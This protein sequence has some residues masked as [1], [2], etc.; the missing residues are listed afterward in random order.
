MAGVGDFVSFL[1][2]NP[3]LIFVT[4]VIGLTGIIIWWLITR[5]DNDTKVNDLSESKSSCIYN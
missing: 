4:I 3:T 1:F 2:K 5:S